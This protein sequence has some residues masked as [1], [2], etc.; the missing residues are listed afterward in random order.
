MVLAHHGAA[1]SRSAR[2][3]TESRGAS[4][5]SLGVGALLVLACI[6]G[7]TALVLLLIGSY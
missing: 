7:G 5:G 1:P 2:S 3:S 4:L 6:V